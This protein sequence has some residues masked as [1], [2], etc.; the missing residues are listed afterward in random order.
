MAQLVEQSAAV[1]SNSTA[2]SAG[3]NAASNVNRMA[4]FLHSLAFVLGFSVIFTLLG[5]VAGLVGVTISEWLQ[6]IGAILLFILALTTLGVFRWGVQRIEASTDVAA[7]PPLRALVS[8]M[9]FFNK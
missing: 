9:N 2:Q 4:I 3:P 8:V 7:N 6:R 1:S 5:V